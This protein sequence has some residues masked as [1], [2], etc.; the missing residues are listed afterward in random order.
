[1]ISSHITSSLVAK[2]ATSEPRSATKVFSGLPILHWQWLS[3]MLLVCALIFVK[4]VQ[5]QTTVGIADTPLLA[6]KSAPGLVMLTMSRDHRLY[7]SAYNDVS[8][9]NGDGTIDVGFKPSISYYGY[10]VSDRCYRYDT[11]VTPV[12]YVPVSNANAATGC[13]FS[14]ST[15]RW[16]GNW[17]NWALTSRMDSLRKVLYGGYRRTETAS[18]TVLEAANIPGDSHVWGKEYRR[19]ANEGPD[20]YDITQYTPLPT[21]GVGQMHIFLLKSEGNPDNVYTNRDVPTFRVVQNVNALIDRVWIWSSSERPIGGPNGSF[22][23]NRP[24]GRSI[25]NLPGYPYVANDAFSYEAVSYP[26]VFTTQVRVEACVSIGG[27]REERCKGYPATNPTA[28]RPTGVL[29]EYSEND[30]LKFGLITGSYQNHYSGGVVRKDIESFKNEI[31]ETTGMYKAAVVGIAK[32]VDRLT[33]YGFSGATNYQYDC[34]FIFNALRTQDT[35]T[36]C[37]MWGAPVAEMM[38]E[39]LRYFGGKTPEAA[40]ITGVSGANTPDTRLGLP[41][42]STWANPY[43][44]KSAG[45]NPICS[46]PVQMVIA[47][48]IT[49]FD[50]DQLPGSSFGISAGNGAALSASAGN[51]NA[52]ALNVTTQADAIWASEISATATVV[53]SAGTLTWPAGTLYG[54]A[55]NFLFGQ[56]TVGNFDGNPTGKLA[57]TFATMR[58]HAPDET[59]TQGSYYAAGVARYGQKTGV[60]VTDGLAGGKNRIAQVDNISIALGSVVPRVEFTYN[61]RNVTLVPFSK[62]VGGGI[63]SSARGD[64]Q[65]TGLITLLYFDRIYNT[66]PANTFASQNGGRPYLRFM[67]SFSDIDQGADNEADAN[68]YFTVEVTA[69]GTLSVQADAYYEAGSIKQNMGYIIS[70][71][72]DDGVYLVVGD[73]VNNPRYFLD[74]LA[75]QSPAAAAPAAVRVNATSLPRTDVRNFTLGAAGS[76]ATYVPKDPLWYAAKHG[77]AGLFDSNGDP[78]N[79]FKVT[80]PSALPAQ[81]GKAFRA[82]AALAA[83]SNTSVTGAS[84]QSA[85]SAAVYQANYDS[86]TWSS[87]IY[88][89]AVTSSGNI[90]NTPTWEASTK[91]PAL[92]ARNLFLGRGTSTLALTTSAYTSLSA[93][94]QTDFGTTATFAYLLGDQTNEERFGGTLRNRGAVLTTETGSVIGDIVNSDPKLI[95][96][97]DFGYGPSDATYTTF[98]N[99][100]TSEMLAVSTNGGYFHI[101]DATPDATGGRE[102]LGFMPQAARTNVKQLAE[103]G[104]VHRNFVDGPVVIGHA[105]IG[106][107]SDP[108]NV[109]WR[110]IAVGTGGVGASTIFAVDTTT[111]NFTANSILWEFNLNTMPSANSDTLGKIIGKPVIG[112][113]ANGTWVTIFGNGYNSASGLAKLYVVEL[114]TGNILRVL[115]AG[116]LTGN[117]MGSI[118]A[119]RKT[120]GDQDTIE[121]VYGV[122]YRGAVWRFDLSDATP[123]NWSSQTTLVYRAPVGRPIT[124]ELKIGPPPISANTSA[125]GKMIYFGTGQFLTASDANNTTTQALYGIYDDMSTA[126][127]NRQSNSTPTQL[128]AETQLAS[129]S[130][131]MAPNGSLRTTTAVTTPWY[132]GTTQRG[133]RIPLTGANVDAGERVIARPLLYNV[134]TSQAVIFTSFVPGTDPCTAGVFTWQTG[135]DA[136]TGGSTR[137]YL[138]TP[139]NS[140]KVVGGSPRGAFVLNIGSRAFLVSS[141]TVFDGT[142]GFPSGVG[143]NGGQTSNTLGQNTNSTGSGSTEL[144]TTGSCSSTT[145]VSG[146][147]RQIWKQI[148]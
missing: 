12:R 142:G 41:L 30:A 29:H 146:A 76:S 18:T 63:I 4:N 17:L 42:V 85:G 100:I 101:F 132:S 25:N 60:A 120:S 126:F 134:G 55:K 56:T 144:C 22:G 108:S 49:S 37:R 11:T 66:T 119:V 135:V 54:S 84:Q 122:D 6:L 59:N 83:V 68:V 61:G 31:D 53:T 14:G 45:G 133:W 106:I 5:A 40:F 2:N 13:N 147:R 65:P 44:P 20:A 52:T 98:V 116:L 27:V 57:T 9:I 90:S 15:G 148:K 88:S 38:F 97:E 143:E 47:D 51:L 50:S 8:D 111:N 139:A 124:G 117:G 130:I 112:K 89:F 127:A 58:G 32:T 24:R 107:P 69:A 125:S 67:A 140:I 10:F 21:P 74:T 114:A 141:Y 75:G 138:N 87:R 121:F 78:T 72:T 7:Y 129:M 33:T 96:K 23:F 102:L 93:A 103:P 136:L 26:A 48:P 73:E 28:W 145:P 113:L 118:E 99:G 19:V 3:A 34:G 36:P 91:V 71:T 115:N 128:V 82:A 131:S 70:G 43:R 86:I 109:A 110:S 80:N 62:S 94:E 92:N 123:S 35:G 104:Y 46:K 95:L 16:H 137:V 77:G 79:Y 105:K 39:G 1:M 81:M 64:F